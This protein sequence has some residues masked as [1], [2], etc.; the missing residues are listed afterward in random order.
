MGRS[1]GRRPQWRW[2]LG[3]CMQGVRWQAAALCD[4]CMGMR[5]DMCIEM[6]IDL[7]IGTVMCIGTGLDIGVDMV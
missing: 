4:R 6:C 7:C 1:Y 3:E 5:T 2:G